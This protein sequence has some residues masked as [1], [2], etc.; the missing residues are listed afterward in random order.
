[1]SQVTH[2]IGVLGVGHLIQHM[3][4][5]IVKAVAASEI[6]LSPRNAKRVQTLCDRYEF[7]VAHDNK[8]L[9]QRSQYVVIAVRPF[10]VEEAIAGLP[11]RPDQTVVSLCAGVP[12]SIFDK[13]VSGAKVF[14]ALPVTASEFGA[15]P[16]SIF[17]DDPV[18]AGMLKECGPVIPFTSEEEFETA[19]VMGCYYGW[20]QALVAEVTQWLTENGVECK[21]ARNL[22]AEMTMS[23]ATTIRKRPNTAL[24]DLVDEL[25]IP[26]SFTGMGVDH[27]RSKGAFTPWREACQAVLDKSRNGE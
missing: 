1:M 16:T 10:Q 24:E 5:G 19:S 12:I 15:S 3:A 6:L 26:G 17:P 20:V 18:V 9:V 23:G 21:T 8:S 11:W 2:K 4:E 7:D 13:H 14:R 22:A 25:C 27:L